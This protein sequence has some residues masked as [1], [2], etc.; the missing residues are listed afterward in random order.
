MQLLRMYL[1]SLNY[2]LFEPVDE[3]SAT[4]NWPPDFFIDGAGA[5]IT[6]GAI[7]VPAAAASLQ[8][9]VDAHRSAC[10]FQRPASGRFRARHPQLAADTAIECDMRNR[11]LIEVW[12]AFWIMLEGDYLCPSWCISLVPAKIGQRRQNRLL[13]FH[14]MKTTPRTVRGGTLC[15]CS[16]IL[17]VMA[18]LPMDPKLQAGLSLAIVGVYMGVVFKSPPYKS[19]KLNIPKPSCCRRIAP[20]LSSSSAS[21]FHLETG[22]LLDRLICTALICNYTLGLVEGREAT[23][24]GMEWRSSCMLFEA[25]AW[26]GY[27]CYPES[28]AAPFPF[29]RQGVFMDFRPTAPLRASPVTAM[30]QQVGE[31]RI[32]SP[33]ASAPHGPGPAV[34]LPTSSPT[35]LAAPGLHIHPSRFET[36]WPSHSYRCRAVDWRL[37]VPPGEWKKPRLPHSSRR[38]HPFPHSPLKFRIL[39]LLDSAASRFG[40]KANAKADAHSD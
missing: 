3:A 34:T 19:W 22:N 38:P 33:H 36:R 27:D 32:A 5:L 39:L 31:A 14:S 24:A 23:M 20:A 15:C 25:V 28:Q 1:F 12:C 11:R 6:L 2:L 37:N 30:N 9:T 26:I 4:A 40:V 10:L 17:I 21:H 16:R 8:A 29:Q 13:P 18:Q 35:F 7:L